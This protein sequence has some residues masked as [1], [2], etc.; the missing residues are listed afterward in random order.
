M[1]W[2]LLRLVD[3]LREDACV[4]ESEEKERL[5]DGVGE[6]RGLA[7]QFSGLCWIGRYKPLHLGQ[8]VEQLRGR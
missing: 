3:D 2:W 5:E 1:L 7:Q 4:Y 6:L 8:Y